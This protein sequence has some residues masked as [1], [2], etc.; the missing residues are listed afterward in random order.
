VAFLS[1]QNSAAN[2]QLFTNPGATA[3]AGNNDP[4]NGTIVGGGNVVDY[5][6]APDS[7]RLAYLADEV[8][9]LFELYTAL[10][11]GM[12]NQAVGG[13]SGTFDV[14][15]GSFVWAPDSSL[16]AFV[17]DGN[18]DD[19]FELY[20]VNPAT[21]ARTR[22]SQAAT[23]TQMVTGSPSWAPDSSRIAYLG[24]LLTNTVD[25]L[26]T[27]LPMVADTSTRINSPLLGG[28]VK[29]ALLPIDPP[30]WAPDS[31]RIAYVAQQDVV[32]VNEVYA[33]L[34]DGSSN[35]KLSGTMATDGDAQL[36]V[37]GEV[38]SPDT[39]TLTLS[40]RADQLLDGT[41]EL[42]AATDTTNPLLTGTPMTP[43]AVLT[44]ALWAPD[45]SNVIYVSS[46]DTA[47]VAEVYMSSADGSTR[48]KISGPLVAGG[49]VVPASIAWAP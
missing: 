43:T 9:D 8:A 31:S 13:M 15:L 39:A 41:L 23:A 49:D 46:E 38:W 42:R 47:N 7:S 27:S 20:V 40:Y 1:T 5:D 44:F 26:F 36:G 32:G 24:D 35:S 25:E 17:A 3:G 12:G 30:S 4:I 21:A 33:G 28:D 10:P 11:D 16:I 45:G 22:V 37:D 6:W 19:A 48:Q 2:V 29:T 34:A 14:L 18:V